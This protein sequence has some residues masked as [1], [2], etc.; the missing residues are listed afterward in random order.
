MWR[1]SRLYGCPVSGSRMLQIRTSVVAAAN[2]TRKAVVG[3]GMT[4]MVVSWIAVQS[5]EAQINHLVVLVLDHIENVVSSRTVE[6]HGFLQ[7]RNSSR[8][9]RSQNHA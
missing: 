6:S 4:R 2:G 1:Q 5:G 7:S 9:S 3:C 8:G